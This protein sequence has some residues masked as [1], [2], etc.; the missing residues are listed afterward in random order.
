MSWE[1]R[2]AVLHFDSLH[3]V[4]SMLGS[5]CQPWLSIFWTILPSLML[6]LNLALPSGKRKHLEV[7]ESSKVGD[8]KALAQQSLGHRFLSLVTVCGKILPDPEESL[9]AAGLQDGDYVTVVSSTTCG[10]AK[11]LCSLVL[12][13]RKDHHMGT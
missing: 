2:Q 12:W 6:R 3:L 1:V 4:A 7:A 8:L 9:Q 11:T 13:W 5:K 10:N